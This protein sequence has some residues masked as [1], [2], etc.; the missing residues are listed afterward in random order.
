VRAEE[1]HALARVE[2]EHWFYRGK[3]AIVRHWLET[4]AALRADDVLV[5]VGAGTGQFIVELADRCR[6][7][8]VEPDRVG[9]QIASTTRAHLVR[10]SI[11]AL[12]IA[13]QRAAAV[14]ALDVV[15]HVD[16]DVAAVAEL[17]RIT[18]PGGL[19]VLHVPAFPGLWSD[20]DE[21]LG[22]RRRYTRATLRALISA[23]GLVEHRC[24]Y[25]NSAAF[26]PILAY[27][28]LRSARRPGSA[29]RLEDR[30]P[31]PPIN[32]LLY[33]LFVVPARW[34]WFAPP[35]GV[36]ILGVARKRG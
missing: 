34:R 16:D 31:S 24:V 27:R 12:P 8:G 9:L 26:L 29:D 4:A 21:A 15:E 5:D 14:T 22:H 23:A 2:R 13:S 11:A 25:V 20:W 1:F 36:S 35:F 33:A 17:A 28:W 18:R 3:R 7:V 10:G 6:A 32:R 30:V 19:V